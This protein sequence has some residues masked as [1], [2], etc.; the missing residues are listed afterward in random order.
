MA[1]NAFP[2]SFFGLAAE[3]TETTEKIENKPMEEEY[4]STIWPILYFEADWPAK[5]YSF[6]LGVQLIK[7]DKAT[8]EEITEL[9]NYCWNANESGRLNFLFNTGWF[10]KMDRPEVTEHVSV[11]EIGVSFVDSL[12]TA[13]VESFLMCLQL[14]HS[15]AAT[16]PF[17]F[18][19]QVR[20]ESIEEVDTT[21]DFSGIS[22]D[23]PPV[24]FA[25]TFKIGDLQLLRAL[26]SALVKF[27]KLDGWKK[28]ISTEEFFA[29]CD[30]KASQAAKK[31]IV[32]LL[33]THG[34]YSDISEEERK[35]AREQLTASVE[36]AISKGQAS[37]FWKDF[38]KDS[39]PEAFLERQEEVFSSRT[40]LGRAL[41]LFFEGLQLPLQHAFLSMC[42]V[43]ETLFTVEEGEIT[44]QFATRLANTTGDTFERRKDIF[45]RAR[46]LYRERS[47][48]VHGRRSIK[49]VESN[50]LKDAFYFGRQS[51]R[52]IFCDDTRMKLYSDPITSDK[53]KDPAK[54]IKGIKEYFRD[55][56][57]RHD[58]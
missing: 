2:F 53:T 54:A 41:N 19:A 17:K 13:V 43:L 49:T 16:C 11:S 55:L 29:A 57:L 46:K 52:H 44:Y 3:D 24:H 20:A 33:M 50:I 56:A 42:L 5:G 28:S 23:K 15:T 36:E 10:L 1:S 30:R 34:Y 4:S 51:L 7:A 39:F 45:E 21:D 47:N 14:V 22:S 37:N 32:G 27:R 12:Q 18:P 38:Y 35:K 8:L 9:S 25:E 6:D 26:W 48:V 58:L 31:K 40:R